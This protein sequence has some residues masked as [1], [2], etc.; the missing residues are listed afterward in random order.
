ME[1]PATWALT[2]GTTTLNCGLTRFLF[3][4][5]SRSTA[6][7][8]GVLSTTGW[9]SVFIEAASNAPDKIKPQRMQPLRRNGIGLFGI[10]IASSHASWVHP[11]GSPIAGSIHPKEW[12]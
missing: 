6:W 3:K 8:A 1:F 2:G 11:D 5:I 7:A 12:G 4:S 9:A 10:D